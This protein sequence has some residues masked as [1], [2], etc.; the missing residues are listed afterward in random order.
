ME[1]LNS[2][3]R[4]GEWRSWKGRFFFSLLFLSLLLEYTR[5]SWKICSIAEIHCSMVYYW[6]RGRTKRIRRRGETWDENWTIYARNTGRYDAAGREGPGAHS[7]TWERVQIPFISRPY[8]VCGVARMRVRMRKRAHGRILHEEYC[9]R[10]TR[11]YIVY[12]YR[13]GTRFLSRVLIIHSCRLG[14]LLVKGEFP[15][16]YPTQ[17]RDAIDTNFHWVK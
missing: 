2:R 10:S 14:K 15:N 12:R 16:E 3:R 13:S 5:Q 7:V 1:F 17:S 11:F 6:E 9:A 8:D 4:G